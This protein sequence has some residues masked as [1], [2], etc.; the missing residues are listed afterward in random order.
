MPINGGKK[1]PSRATL[2]YPLVKVCGLT[3]SED[4]L[5]VLEAGADIIGLNF[6]PESPRYL[7]LFQAE[8]ICE[9]IRA[10]CSGQRR[11]CLIM[12]VVANPTKDAL[13]D[14]Q[15]RLAIDAV[16]FHG[17]ETPEICAYV[18]PLLSI[19]AMRLHQETDLSDVSL[20]LDHVDHLLLDAFH[21]GLRGGSGQRIETKVL[22]RLLPIMSSS[23]I[24]GGLNPENVG[25]IVNRYSPF[26]V[27]VCSGVEIS[28][29][30]KSPQLVRAF[31]ANAKR[32]AL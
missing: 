29:G 10:N 13:L 8:Q 22:D 1:E 20:W 31:V 18:R 24:A 5:M 30:H 32:Q 14:L 12:A 6:C 7:S 16:Q 19:K 2:P 4:A 9:D 3:T 11:S 25:E 21:P 27:D 17:E 28:P 23:F 15:R 26:G